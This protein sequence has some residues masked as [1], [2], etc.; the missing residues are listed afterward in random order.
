MIK[1][2]K[3]TPWRSKKY[4]DAARD[5]DCT[6]RLIG[7]NNDTTTVVLCHRPGAGM[8]TKSSD[9]DAADG[10][11]HCHDI[12][13]GRTKPLNPLES[14]MENFDRGRLETIINRIQRGI[15]K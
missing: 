5:Q 1:F 6:L 15:I 14:K 11:T 2:P 10:C 4:R 3:K 9:H 8:G 13:D 7:C 12:L